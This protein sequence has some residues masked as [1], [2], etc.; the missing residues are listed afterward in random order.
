MRSGLIPAGLLPVTLI[1][2][3]TSGVV[4]LRD[5]ATHL[6]APVVLVVV[7]VMGRFR[8]AP[9]L[10]LRAL[11]AGAI[12]TTLYDLFRFSMIWLHFMSRDPIPHIGVALHLTPA[13]IFG[14]LWR[15]LGN[16]GGLA[17]A[18]FALGFRGVRAGVA[19][20]LFVCAG[21]LAVLIFS[22]GGQ[23]ALWPLNVGTVIMATVGHMIYGGVLGA[24]ASRW[25]PKRVERRS[26]VRV[27]PTAESTRERAARGLDR[28]QRVERACLQLARSG[29]DLT[30]SAIA[31]KTGIGRSTLS[32]R[33]EL[34]GAIHVHRIRA[35]A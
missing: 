14:Y 11:L 27:G 34:N 25:Q 7:F 3:A 22:P 24:L 4:G 23:A 33:P 16:G 5:L 10:V 19:Y 21:L 31:T 28:L 29:Q 30:Y 26:P 12:S 35:A 9:R 15:Y 6:L 1:G 13:W 20:G 2:F 32:R 17:L 18:F 8:P